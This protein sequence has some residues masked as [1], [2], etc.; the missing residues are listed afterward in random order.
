MMLAWHVKLV[1]IGEG[2]LSVKLDMD[3]RVGCVAVIADGDYAKMNAS[4]NSTIRID[5]A[6]TPLDL[7]SS[8]HTKRRVSGLS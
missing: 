2:R 5:G 3:A 8:E 6:A 4:T 1:R 7:Y